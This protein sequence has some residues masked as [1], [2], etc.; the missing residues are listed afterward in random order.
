MRKKFGKLMWWLPV[1]NAALVG[2]VLYVINGMSLEA[3]AGQ[4]ALI[5]M[6]IA[7]YALLIVTLPVDLTS[8]QTKSDDV[9]IGRSK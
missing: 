9:E 7:G 6:G 8:T 3:V 5:G 1:A 2:F 4:E